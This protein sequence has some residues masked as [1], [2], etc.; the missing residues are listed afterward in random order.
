MMDFE[1]EPEVDSIWHTC[2]EDHDHDQHEG[3]RLSMTSAE[4]ARH[5]LEVLMAQD[6][7]PKK[8]AVD[9]LHDI[10]L[11]AGCE[12]MLKAWFQ[13]LDTDHSGRIDYTEFDK[14]LK[15]LKF[16]GG[17]KQTHKLWQ[18]L[19]DD[20]SGAIS[21]DEFTRPEEA[22]LWRSFSKFVG[23]TFAGT[24]D[25]LRRLQKHY[26]DSNGME[27]AV[28][29]ALS[30]QEFC[31]SLAAFGW[32]GGQEKM[33]FDAFSMEGENEVRCIYARGMRWVDREVKMFKLKQAAKKKA[34]K[35]AGIR[36]RSAHEAR[37]ALKSFKAFLKKH[38]GNMLRAWRKAL[39]VDGSMTLQ[40]SELFKAV[41]MLNWKGNCRALWQAL[42]HDASGITTIEELDP[43]S[44]QLLAY[45]REWALQTS[46]SKRPSEAFE[47]LDRFRKKRLTHA[48]F[49]QELE[50]HGFG[51]NAK[52]LASILDWQE[53]KHI[54]ARDFEFMDVWRAPAWLTTVADQAAADAFRKQLVARH[55]H[56]LKAWRFAMDKDCSNSC[57]WHEFQEA[58]KLVRFHGNLA[59]AW[60]AL[61]ADCSG[62]ISLKEVDPEAHECLTNFKTWADAEFGGVRSAFKVLDADGS[63]SLNFKEFK[64]ACRM[65]GFTG[66]CKSLFHNLDQMGKGSLQLH[67]VSFLDNWPNEDLAS[68]SE[69]GSLDDGAS[70]RRRYGET[71][72]RLLEY[73]TENPGPGAYAVP[74]GFGLS[75]RSPGRY[76]GAFTMQGRHKP[77][78]QQKYIS[79]AQYSPCMEPT[80]PR[81]P[82]WTFSKRP[83]SA[84]KAQTPRVRRPITP[85]PG[86]YDTCKGG[87]SPVFSVRPRRALP[88]HP[89]ATP[90]QVFM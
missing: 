90:R 30:E 54:C 66:E 34:E 86:S 48:E 11:E 57:N 44:A 72:D 71:G 39:D 15:D 87:G 25:M 65:Y 28:D 80:S 17:P 27:K 26:A 16:T 53:K 83:K 2:A 70:S 69:F 76:C 23:S 79:P 8:S 19:D 33:F 20:M 24:K 45:F 21:F 9:K 22:E 73:F 12:T 84:Q 61:D 32:S 58:A 5:T 56:I 6:D 55:G 60:L 81:K 46:P 82:A 88:L 52:Q 40:R 50:S 42:D 18:E 38:F 85:G 62:S 74:N 77:K 78:E 31:E 3:R 29:K 13:F 67:E 68:E 47:V 4:H 10:A 63:G 7:A 75:D 89:S 59:G 14:G 43:Q 51:R 64:S 1:N 49:L 41:K 37:A 35:M 36:V